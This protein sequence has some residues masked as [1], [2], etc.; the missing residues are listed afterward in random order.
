MQFSNCDPDWVEVDQLFHKIK[1]PIF[2]PSCIVYKF[3][4]GGCSANYYG[5]T[6]CHFKV[7]MFE[8]LRVSA[9]T[10]KREWKGITILP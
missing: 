9:L 7:R 10:G 4:C 5:K 3:K 6:K 1:I 8:H 2:L